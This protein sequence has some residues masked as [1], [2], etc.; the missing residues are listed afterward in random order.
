MFERYT[1]AVAR[2]LEAALA[3]AGRHGALEI[4]PLHLL[5]GL[6]E[7]QEGRAAA[8]L[9][10]GGLAPEIALTALTVGTAEEAPPGVELPFSASAEQILASAREVARDLFGE[11][12]VASEQL[13]LALVREDD[14]LRRSLESL[15]LAADRLE[16]DILAD[17]GPPL[18]LDEPLHLPETTEQIDTARI[19]DAC[20]NRAREALRV[21]EDYCRFVLDD[22]FLTG[23]LK[24]L[25]H[26]LAAALADVPGPLLLAA[27]DTLGDVGTGI[28][29]PQELYRPTLVSVVEANLKRLQEALRSLE[30][31]GKVRSPGLGQAV[32]TL[33]YRAYTLE[34]A[35]VPGET[36]R[37]RLADARLYVL[38]TFGLCARSPEWVV[39][40]AVAGGAQVVQLREKG[41]TDRDLLERTRQ[42]SRWARAGGALF[43]LND[44]PDLARLADADGV[45][46]G[47][48]ELPVREARRVVGPDALV[49]VSTHD[50]EQVRQAVRD[51]ASYIGV[52][53][54][55]PSGTKEFAAF[56]GLEFV[57]QATAETS[58]PAFAIG[59]VTL[60]NLPEVV[61]AGA[62]RAAV[63]GAICGSEDPCALAA[64]MRRVLDAS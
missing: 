9:A 5:E 57:R 16:A 7:E 52:G 27:R 62:R 28:A 44:R 25:R 2:A 41:L 10:A 47:Q 11:R 38:V 12:T 8:L 58:L 32:E 53:P 43:V 6:L 33:R 51:G 22:A 42:V 49:G 48:D 45:H 40:E 30:E 26:D 24:R 36:A 60:K 59:G 3:W 15:G 39:R 63:S 35:I 50:L 4:R 14:D 37:R 13:L 1:P 55:F 20:A 23:E 17:L 54:T 61:A 31:Y 46:V 29:T 56:P 18:R 21:V 64:A 34:R 19:L